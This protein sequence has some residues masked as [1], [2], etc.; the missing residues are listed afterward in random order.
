MIED[1]E[2]EIMAAS[3]MVDEKR[4]EM[5]K[6]IVKSMV[7]KDIDLA[8]KVTNGI[9]NKSYASEIQY[10]IVKYLI[11]QNLEKAIEVAYDI[12]DIHW[13]ALSFINIARELNGMDKKKFLEIL[14]EVIKTGC[15]KWN[16]LDYVVKELSI[17][18]VE[19]IFNMLNKI[20]N[21]RYKIK[22]MTGVLNELLK[23]DIVRAEEFINNIE[24]DKE[25]REVLRSTHYSLS[26]A[27]SY[28]VDIVSKNNIER[29]LEIAREV[30]NQ[31]WQS[32]ALCVV[33][34]AL[35][36]KDTKMA[37]KV[38]EEIQNANWELKAIDYMEK[39][40]DSETLEFENLL[41]LKGILLF[42]S[43]EYKEATK[44]FRRV[45]EINPENIDAWYN[46]AYCYDAQE[47]YDISEKYYSKLVEINPKDAKAWNHL[48]VARLYQKKYE[49]ALEAAEKA[50]ELKDDYGNA[51][52]NKG[53]SL[54]YL[55]RYKEAIK[56]FK[57]CIEISDDP[58]AWY[59]MS[60]SYTN[61]GM[62][63]EAKKA[64]EEALRRRP[65][66]EEIEYP[67]F[68]CELD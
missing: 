7:D 57:K 23:D 47:K 46:L 68:L 12:K 32:R 16:V 38:L 1:F 43:K 29:A 40:I 41:L 4:E 3:R 28:I 53:M 42:N 33:V 52:Y 19:S 58:D 35:T 37:L 27:M 61:M 60:I 50:I 8:V 20:S 65:Y 14:E 45:T 24:D 62:K 25:R 26:E 55:E 2:N 63:K 31:Y 30:K 21:K 51:W 36:K 9:K 48:A 10:Y 11:P 17:E 15:D 56:A 5:I 13:K 64:L 18:D 49:K 34:R 66:Y 54:H 6:N 44:Y 22:L 39:V 67:C 59:A